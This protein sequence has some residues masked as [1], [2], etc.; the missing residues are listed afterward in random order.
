MSRSAKYLSIYFGFGLVS[1]SEMSVHEVPRCQSEILSKSKASAI[2]YHVFFNNCVVHTTYLMLD[3]QD[4]N[5]TAKLRIPSAHCLPIERTES[6][7]H[8]FI[9]FAVEDYW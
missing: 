6:F 8:S 4:I 3:G 9:F 2:F 5:I 7:K 1:Q